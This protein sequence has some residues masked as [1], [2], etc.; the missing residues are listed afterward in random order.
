MKEKILQLLR[1]YTGHE[2][3]WLTESGD[4]AILAALNLARLKTE[5]KTVLIPDQGGWLSYQKY[6][7]KVGFKLAALKTD[8]GI[9][10]TAILKKGLANASCL[11]YQNPAGY[12]A[13]QP[14][15]DIYK[16]CKGTTVILDVTGCLSDKA[17]CN[18][19]YADIM[20]GSFGEHKPVNLGYGG[21]IS[22]KEAFGNPEEFLTPFDDSYIAPLH[23]KLIEL[24]ARY[25][26]LTET[27]R[28]VKMQLK[29][30]RI[31][32]PNRQGINV[33]VLYA[34]ESEKMKL[35]K[36]CQENKFEYTECPRY[37]RVMT[38]AISIEIKRGA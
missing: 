28:K 3:V 1:Q 27:A 20:V 35:V 32:H 11:L 9:I 7:K 21:F 17:L 29:E 33:V 19:A 30:K 24:P 38:N 12:F 22:M 2:N 18:G 34:D 16:E 25:K 5:K 13:D 6:P 26:K 10:D 37:I 23:Q 15:A 31:A 14:I 4:A 8:L 36:F